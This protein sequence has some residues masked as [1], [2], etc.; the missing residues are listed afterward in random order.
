MIIYG[1]P[2]FALRESP[3]SEPED[4]EEVLSVSFWFGGRGGGS[5][6]WQG[7]QCWQGQGKLEA[8]WNGGLILDGKWA[9]EASYPNPT[10]KQ[11][12]WLWGCDLNIFGGGAG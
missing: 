10:V 3:S 12:G 1:L 6:K 11:C 8:Q 9:L 2:Q 7:Q 4:S 5:G